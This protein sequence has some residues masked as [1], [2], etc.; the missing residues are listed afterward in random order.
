[1]DLKNKNLDKQIIMCMKCKGRLFFSEF[2]MHF[3]AEKLAK[4]FEIFKS[5][6]KH[7]IKLLMF[8]FF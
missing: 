6:I 5:L 8:F 2:A 1:M 4:T 7:S 3:E